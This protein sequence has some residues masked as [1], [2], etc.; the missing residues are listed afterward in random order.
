MKI[1][2]QRCPW[3]GSTEFVVGYQGY[4]AMMTYTPG[5]FTG[6]K[7]KHLICKNCGIVVASQVANTAKY[8]DASRAW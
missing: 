1:P 7:I 4:E 6:K 2:V 8:A 5:G 3:C